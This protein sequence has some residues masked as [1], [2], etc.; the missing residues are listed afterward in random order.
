MIVDAEKALASVHLLEPMLSR[1]PGTARCRVDA[2]CGL[3]DAMEEV[4]GEAACSYR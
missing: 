4:Y 3:H 1:A 2:L